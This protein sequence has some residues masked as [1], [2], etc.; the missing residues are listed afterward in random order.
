MLIMVKLLNRADQAH[1][2]PVAAVADAACAEVRVAEA[3]V[4]RVASIPVRGRP[5]AAIG[6]D[7]ADRRPTAV[8]CGWQEDGSHIFE[9]NPLRYD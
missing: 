9:D 8:A 6:T 7:K 4:V 1:R 3:H 2:E 5:I